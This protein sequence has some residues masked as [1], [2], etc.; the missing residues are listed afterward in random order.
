MPTDGVFPFG[1]AELETPTE[2][3]EGFGDC[4]LQR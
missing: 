1:L 2:L 4:N 3:F